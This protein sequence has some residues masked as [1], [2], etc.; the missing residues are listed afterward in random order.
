MHRDA[1]GNW[2]IEDHEEPPL[3]WVIPCSADVAALRGTVPSGAASATEPLVAGAAAAG[4]SYAATA[5]SGS[6]SPSMVPRG[7][8][9]QTV[10]P[11]PPGALPDSIGY[12]WKWYVSS[13]CSALGN[14]HPHPLLL[15]VLFPFLLVLV[16]IVLILAALRRLLCCCR[17]SK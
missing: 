15:V 14:F 9:L 10:R 8:V 1:E 3:G 12:G 7:T 5:E 2:S 11:F 16:I 13:L 17:S 6:G 4:S